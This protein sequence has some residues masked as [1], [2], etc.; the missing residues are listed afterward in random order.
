MEE[1]D[2]VFYKNKD[3]NIMSGGYLI[4]SMNN[5]LTQMVNSNEKHK[6]TTDNQTGGGLPE[7]LHNLAVPAGLLYLQQTFN[8]DNNLYENENNNSNTKLSNTETYKKSNKV[9]E[10]SLYEKLV[11]MVSNNK[12]NRKNKTRKNNNR[13]K[14]SKTKKTK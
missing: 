1:Q 14:Q 4:K 9:V 8:I 12:K 6:D 11:H 10:P 7:I 13:K 5:S 3:G 2:L